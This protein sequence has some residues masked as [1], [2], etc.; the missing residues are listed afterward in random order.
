MRCNLQVKNIFN[1]LK[2]DNQLEKDRFERAERLRAVPE[3]VEWGDENAGNYLLDDRVHDAGQEAAGRRRS[4]WLEA[5]VVHR[6]FAANRDC[7]TLNF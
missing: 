7:V 5:D 6:E 1:I 3:A 2:S 4:W